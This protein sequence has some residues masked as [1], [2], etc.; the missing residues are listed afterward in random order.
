MNTTD[1]KTDKV[2][3]FCISI[4][5]I[6]CQKN[7]FFSTISWQLASE[8]HLPVLYHTIF[9]S[10]PVFLCA[11]NTP[12]NSE[13]ALLQVR[14]LTYIPSGSAESSPSGGLYNWLSIL[15]MIVILG[16]QWMVRHFQVPLS[17]QSLIWDLVMNPPSIPPTLGS[18][19]DPPMITQGCGIII[20]YLQG[21]GI[22]NDQKVLK[23]NL[24]LYFTCAY[25]HHVMPLTKESV[26][27]FKILPLN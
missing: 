25:Y 6:H 17:N 2:N 18:K 16:I 8:N 23:F 12:G 24:I 5:I 19:T 15:K 3:L 22:D 7:R 14:C 11:I 13:Q 10:S 1:I 26:T 20:S 4:H 27:P 9:F 21:K